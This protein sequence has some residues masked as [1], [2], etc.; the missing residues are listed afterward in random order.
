MVNDDSKRD[1][2]EFGS[3]ANQSRPNPVPNS[4]LS[5][6][7]S[8]FAI[9]Y[10]LKG[11]CPSARC[12]RAFDVAQPSR[13]GARILSRSRCAEVSSFS[14]SSRGEILDGF[15]LVDAQ[16]VRDELVDVSGLREE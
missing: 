5:R 8:S 7:E 13:R 15:V 1:N 11:E 3:G 4:S 16:D 12:A 9:H 2:S 6:F 14:S 10:L